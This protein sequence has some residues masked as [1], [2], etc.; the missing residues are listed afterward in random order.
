MNRRG[1]VGRFPPRPAGV[2]FLVLL[3]LAVGGT[4]SNGLPW[5][6]DTGAGGSAGFGLPHAFPVAT[7]SSGDEREA[8]PLVAA[9]PASSADPT[10]A[11]RPFTI[12]LSGLSTSPSAGNA[13]LS[14]QL[15]A[16]A[17]SDLL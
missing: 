14:V 16:V 3:A 7:T 12:T 11:P 1:W 9:A 17:K 8:G 5:S 6:Q 2:A 4:T 15:S 10:L 13:P